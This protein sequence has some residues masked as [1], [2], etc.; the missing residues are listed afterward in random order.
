MT[1]KQ[2]FE[3]LKETAKKTLPLGG[4]AL[5]FGSRARG[6][7]TDSSDWDVLIV[8]DKDKI[9]YQDYVEVAYPFDQL[10]WELDAMISP[11]LYTK[12]DWEKASFTP[13]Y[14]NVMR[15]GVLL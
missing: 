3:K 8:L 13:F 4:M 6:T 1:A 12:S 11:V 9:T 5:L 2:I 14:K 7:A 10:G 15:E